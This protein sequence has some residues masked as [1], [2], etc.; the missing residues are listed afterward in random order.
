MLFLRDRLLKCRLLLEFLYW[1]NVEQVSIC[2]VRLD[3][4]HACTHSVLFPA[5]S[6]GTPRI[7]LP[8]SPRKTPNIQK[9]FKNA[10]N[11]PPR[12]VFS[13][14]RT[15][16]L[17][18]TLTLIQLQYVTYPRQ[19]MLHLFSLSLS[20]SPSSLSLSLSLF[21]LRLSISVL[22]GRHDISVACEGSSNITNRAEFRWRGVTGCTVVSHHI[23]GT[24]PV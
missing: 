18:L 11:L 5:I 14:P 4:S 7:P 6:W 20:L 9:T 15:W 2:F 8:P 16:S 19:V 17:E 12:Y 10:S 1:N 22:A 21:L 3:I 24:L 13:P 23:A